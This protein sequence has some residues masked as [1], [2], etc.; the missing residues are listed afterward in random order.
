MEYLTLHHLNGSIAILKGVTTASYNETVKITSPGGPPRM[1]RVLK[2]E[3]DTV[4]ALI[5]EGAAGLSLTS[6]ATKFTGQQMEV[7]LSPEIIGRKFDGF[8]NPIDG[9]GRIRSKLRRS[10]NGQPINPVQRSYPR[11]YIHTG[12]SA[13]DGLATL[14]R[15]QK[16]PIFSADGLPHDILAAQIATMSGM[17]PQN[18]VGRKL[19]PTELHSP[20]PQKFATVF[21]AMGISHETARF[22]QDS[23]DESGQ[24]Y[25]MFQNL[26]SDPT[27]Q[28]LA[29]PRLALTAAEYLAYDLGYHVLVILTDITSYAEAL[30]E[31][32]SQQGEIPSRKGYPGYMYSDL[33]SLYERA[34]IIK[35]KPGSVTQIPILTMPG[36][37][38]THPIPDLTGYITEGQIVLSRSLHQKNIY[39]PINV[40]PSLSRL[41]KDGIGE[42]YTTK[43]HPAIA[44]KLF[45]T[46]A[47]VEDIRALAAIIGE[48]DL[49]PEDKATL[50]FGKN[51]EQDFLAQS[52][53]AARSLAQTMEIAKTL[54]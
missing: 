43:E 24:A 47:K 28:R 37:D 48:D 14:I 50:S 1:G 18:S 25:I 54:L 49:T 45:A 42:G 4:V 8:G 34:G 51:F 13:I 32:S 40:L 23:F 26:A 39:P 15:G 29:T 53:Q 6:A 52:P 22:F 30:R 41:M 21:A 33:A 10:I 7:A 9:L 35:N 20:K 16:L 44:A 12:I 27:A 2:I 5:F 46:Y 19:R 11:D 36:E 31:I 17:P 38:I 3:G